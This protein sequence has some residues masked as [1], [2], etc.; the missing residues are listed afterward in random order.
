M[1]YRFKPLAVAALACA[2]AAAAWAQDGRAVRVVP[3]SPEV[4]SAF[5][6]EATLPGERAEAISPSEPGI[7]G[8]ARYTGADVRPVDGAAVIEYRFVATGPGRIDIVDLTARAANRWIHLGSWSLESVAGALPLPRRSGSWYAPRSVAVRE[9][10]RI[11]ALDPDGEPTACPTFAVEGALFE[12]VP[13]SPGAFY[14]VALEPGTVRLPPLETGEAGSAFSLA[15]RL[16]ESRPL[17]VSAAGAAAVGGPWRLELAA[18]RPGTTVGPD[19]TVSWDIRAVGRGW[20]GLAAPPALTVEAPDGAVLRVGGGTA[21]AS[22]GSG[23]GAVSGARGAFAVSGPGAYLVR[24]EPYP[25]FDTSTGTLRIASAAAVRVVVAARAEPAW[26]APDAVADFALRGLAALAEAD[27]VWLP[28]L[29]AASDAGGSPDWPAVRLAALGIAGLDSGRG[30][31]SSALFPGTD[32]KV[33]AATLAALGL[34]AAGS[35]A[36]A[37]AES[38]CVFLRLERAAFPRR[39]VSVI[40]DEAAASFGNL[41]RTPYVLP[42]FGWMAALGACLAVV[43]GGAVA[44]A[45]LSGRKD[46]PRGRR[47]GMRVVATVSAVLGILTL[48]LSAASAVERSRPRFVSLGGQA[49]SVPSELAA[50][51]P[52]IEAGSTGRVLRS[53]GRWLFVELDDGRA[54]WLV[55]GDAALY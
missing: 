4:G 34:L 14:A 37:R 51:G 54:S 2:V 17:P 20:P 21:Y 29:D 12:P 41:S 11:T 39:G 28:V 18:P 40:A 7:A 10:F 48:A 49:R 43:A 33:E 52:F 45:A 8:P 19:E 32:D 50:E 26:K 16:I 9:V 55:A 47:S 5:T 1:R 36:E 44:A 31:L 25:W 53:A 23:L 30:A 46:S 24:P 6:I 3:E 15:P 22:G 38:Y 27:S 42:P 13:D 35:D